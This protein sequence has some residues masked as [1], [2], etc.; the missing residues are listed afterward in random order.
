MIEDIT[1][2]DA[3]PGGEDAPAGFSRPPAFA[4]D[5]DTRLMMAF[6]AGEDAAFDRIVKAFERQ[7]FGITSRYLGNTPGAQDCAQEAF[8]RLYRMRATYAPTARLSTLIFR[9]TT[10]LCLNHIRDESR[11]QTISLDTAYGRDE[12]PL[13]ATLVDGACPSGHDAAVAAE[14]AAIVRAALGRIPDRQR[15][16][17]VLHKFDGLSYN[18]IADAMGVNVDAV[19]SLLSRARTSLAEALKPE[20]D[21]GNL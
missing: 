16:A 9:I 19:K 4:E 5:P 6:A 8:C 18:E 15:M 20:I 1:R 7:V 17:L 3:P 14:R 2:P 21:A 12:T 10:N 11:R 13:S